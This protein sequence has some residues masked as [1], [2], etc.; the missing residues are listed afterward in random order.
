MFQIKS[1][2][3]PDGRRARVMAAGRGKRGLI[4][5]VLGSRPGKQPVESITGV[6]VLDV[7]LRH[8]PT[9]RA[10]DVSFEVGVPA[11]L[12]GANGSGK[13]SFLDALTGFRDAAK[14][15]VEFCYDS[16]RTHVERIRSSGEMFRLGMRRTWQHARLIDELS[17]AQLA[18][19]ADAGRDNQLG[20]LLPRGNREK[21]LGDADR[22]LVGALGL[23]HC[24][25]RPARTLSLSEQ[26]RAGL[27][28]ALRG[29]NG[30]LVLDEPLAGL[31][32]DS[33][34]QVIAILSATAASRPL[35]IVEH[36]RNASCF[37]GWGAKKWKI[38]H[39]N[40]VEL[41]G[42]AN[43]D[44]FRDPRKAFRQVTDNASSQEMWR[45]GDKASLTLYR[46]DRPAHGARSC[47]QV[48]LEFTLLDGSQMSLAV[49][50]AMLALLVAPNGWGKSSLLRRAVGLE[51]HAPAVVRISVDG[52][53]VSSPL[54]AHRAGI[55]LTTAGDVP[56]PSF[57]V[58][59]FLELQ[60]AA[61]SASLIQLDQRT[62]TGLLSGGERTTLVALGA[63]KSRDAKVV[64]LDE[65]LLG[66]DQSR[67]MSILIAIQEFLEGSPSVC[68]VALPGLTD[69]DRQVP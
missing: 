3:S 67:A 25:Q 34:S 26:K 63:L 24:V 42:D 51:G 49:G 48:Q 29:G 38:E 6:R 32:S 8:H 33:L 4:A 54:E 1:G 28:L 43:G 17:V 22:K 21:K 20:V 60:G 30:P 37:A 58:A 18:A 41:N 31:D 44:A 59:E 61:Y 16:G 7:S 27:F 55:R 68:V 39:C 19:L 15:S 50:N 9:L 23:E 65:P 64:L 47:Q 40:V 53:T 62:R 56:L 36:E 46:F 52:V 69:D 11:L 5:K 10:A 12:F 66:T 45:L 35:L 14:A 57:T 2:H 13:T